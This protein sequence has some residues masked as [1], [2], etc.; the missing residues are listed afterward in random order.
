MEIKEDEV[1]CFF[2]GRLSVEKNPNV[3]VEVA[4]KIKKI[5]FFI[6]GDGP[7]K[8]QIEASTKI[9]KNNVRYLG[10]SDRIPEYLIAADIFLLPSSIEGFPLSLIEAMSMGVVSIASNVGAI[11]DVIDE[12]KNGYIINPPGSVKEIVK[13]L[14][15][16]SMNH[17]Q[18]K[19]KGLLARET[20]ENKFSLDVLRKNYI[21]TYDEILKK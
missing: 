21:N 2:I 19:Q 16:S 5:K 4:K 14:S 10:Y 15:S 3:V 8:P 9:K 17:K 11:S 12:G 6:V 7:M 20:V 1:A 18:L 13:I